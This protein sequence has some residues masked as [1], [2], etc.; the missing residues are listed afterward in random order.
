MGDIDVDLSGPMFDGR[1]DAALGRIVFEVEKAVAEQGLANVQRILGESIRHHTPY[2]ETRVT[3]ERA[4]LDYVVHDQGVV[5]GPWLEGTSER[6]RST[7][8]KGHHAWRTA[9]QELERQAQSI[10]AEVVHRHLPE[11]GG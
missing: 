2:Y 9:R 10:A 8:F 4:A 3:A 5:Y 1:A 7:S 11:L 6:N